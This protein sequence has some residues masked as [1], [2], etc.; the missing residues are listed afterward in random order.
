M[1]LTTDPAGAHSSAPPD[2]SANPVAQRQL[3]IVTCFVPSLQHGCPFRV[4]LHSWQEPE[5]SRGTQA[6]TSPKDSVFFEARVLLDGICAGYDIC[7]LG[8]QGSKTMADPMC[9][10]PF[11]WTSR[12]HGLR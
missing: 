11:C 4:S 9:V 5:V 10:V 1:P 7:K 12:L 8:N 2:L 3:P 6:L